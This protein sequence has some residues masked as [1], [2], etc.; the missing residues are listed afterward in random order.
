MRMMMMS[1]V[2]VMVKEWVY[3]DTAG[4]VGSIGLVV[5]HYSPS[6][7]HSDDGGDVVDDDDGVMVRLVLV[8]R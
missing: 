5:V 4:E 3:S 1:L 7:R 2:K 8:E 6:L